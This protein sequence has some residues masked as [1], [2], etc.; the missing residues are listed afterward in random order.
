MSND[1][2]VKRK[3]KKN[4]DYKQKCVILLRRKTK[5]SGRYD[6]DLG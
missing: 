1:R 3:N 6:G 5:K 4:K 2:I